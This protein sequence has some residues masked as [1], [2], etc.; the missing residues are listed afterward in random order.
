M[1]VNLGSPYSVL[2]TDGKIN[3][4]VKGSLSGYPMNPY[5][6]KQER[7]CHALAIRFRPGG[8]YLF[9]GVPMNENAPIALFNADTLFPMAYRQVSCQMRR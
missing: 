8:A 9:C 5:S 2:G 4:F 1:V 7:A 3:Y 6:V